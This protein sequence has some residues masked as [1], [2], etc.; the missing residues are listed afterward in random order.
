MKTMSA[1]VLLAALFLSSGCSSV[2]PSEP[3]PVQEQ[4]AANPGNDRSNLIRSDDCYVVLPK[5]YDRQ[6]KY[7]VIIGLYGAMSN[8]KRHAEYFQPMADKYGFLV[9]CPALPEIMNPMAIAAQA[10][11]IL[12]AAENRMKDYSIDPKRVYL[13]SVSFSTVAL[14]R[15]A[16]LKPGFFSGLIVAAPSKSPDIQDAGKDGMANLPVY[17]WQGVNDRLKSSG[18]NIN[19]M[20]NELKYSRVNLKEAQGFGHQSPPIEEW[21]EIINWLDSGK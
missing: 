15:M 8:S 18:Q 13:S 21:D 9:F 6:K 10:E 5:G 4:K 3:L 12:A 16:A 11:S 14:F 19:K 7:L 17:I 2:K 1:G 20:L